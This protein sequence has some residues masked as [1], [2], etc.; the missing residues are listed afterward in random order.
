[1]LVPGMRR[2]GGEAWWTLT[3][4]PLAIGPI[5]PESIS[6][7]LRERTAGFPQCPP[8]ARCHAKCAANLHSRPAVGRPVCPHLVCP[9]SHCPL[10][11][12]A[13]KLSP[14]LGVWV[15]Q[16]H[17]KVLSCVLLLQRPA[18]WIDA[19]PTGTR[20]LTLPTELG[21]IVPL[22]PKCTAPRDSHRSRHIWDTGPRAPVNSTF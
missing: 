19:L 16:V 13:G 7:P 20:A 15:V 9:R 12:R 5:A 14:S 1:M 18:G 4:S 17:D 11:G 8:P 22:W 6:H 3:D 10:P 2:V 21:N